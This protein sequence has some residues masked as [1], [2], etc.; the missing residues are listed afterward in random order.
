MTQDMVLVPAA[1]LRAVLE[2]H[3]RVDY[4]GD[5]QSYCP[6]CGGPIDRTRSLYEYD[7]DNRPI[8]YLGK[9][10]LADMHDADC[11]VLVLKTALEAKPAP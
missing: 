3:A 8:E 4:Q 6:N 7:E 1:A 10:N 11:V 5:E 9:E 2:E